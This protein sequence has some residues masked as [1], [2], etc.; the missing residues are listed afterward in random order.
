MAAN[1]LATWVG[2]KHTLPTASGRS[3]HEMRGTL[4]RTKPDRT[5]LGRRRLGANSRVI[6]DSVGRYPS[7]FTTN[8]GNR[9]G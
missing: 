8:F 9:L 6:T 2:Y 4:N 1:C 3:R 7:V 5:K